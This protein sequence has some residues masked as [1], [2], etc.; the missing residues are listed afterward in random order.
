MRGSSPTFGIDPFKRFVYAPIEVNLVVERTEDRRVEI[1]HSVRNRAIAF[2]TDLTNDATADEITKATHDRFG[3]IDILVNNAGIGPGSIRPDSWQPPS[4][5]GRSRL[6]SG[7]ALS[8]STQPH[9]CPWRTPSLKGT[10][11]RTLG[12]P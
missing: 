4:S 5:S 11:I 2:Q 1:G 3:R 10:R 8:R 12:P 6:I 7:A 9:R